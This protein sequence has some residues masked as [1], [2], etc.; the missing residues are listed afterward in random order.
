MKQPHLG[1]YLRCGIYYL[2]KNGGQPVHMAKVNN[3]AFIPINRKSRIA[4]DLSKDL[5]R[6]RRLKKRNTSGAALMT[7]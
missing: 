4:Q 1:T 3:M 5:L 6:S 2:V 7:G